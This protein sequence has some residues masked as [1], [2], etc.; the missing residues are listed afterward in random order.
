[1]DRG[2]WRAR[3]HGVAK[4]QTRLKRLSM[5]MHASSTTMDLTVNKNLK[6][7]VPM[8]L[9]I[10]WHVQER[11][12]SYCSEWWPHQEVTS[13][14]RTGEGAGSQGRSEGVQGQQGGGCDRGPSQD[15]PHSG[16]WE[17][18]WCWAGGQ[19]GRQAGKH[20]A[21]SPRWPGILL[22]RGPAPRITPLPTAARSLGSPADAGLFWPQRLELMGWDPA[23]A[24]DLPEKE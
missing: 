18:V 11:R 16:W 23:W 8:E 4:S 14:K 10:S 20:P 22:T 9:A 13:E 6:I 19:G 24:L 15:E 7:P 1:M 5:S 12:R 3:V 2:A 21:S 17:A